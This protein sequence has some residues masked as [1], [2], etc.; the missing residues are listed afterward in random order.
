MGKINFEKTRPLWNNSDPRSQ[1]HNAE[2]I[3]GKTTHGTHTRLLATLKTFYLQPPS[4]NWLSEK[5]FIPKIKK[6]TAPE[7]PKHCS[8]I[9]C[10]KTMDQQIHFPQT[11]QKFVSPETTTERNSPVTWTRFRKKNSSHKFHSGARKCKQWTLQNFTMRI[12]FLSH[13]HKTKSCQ[14]SKQ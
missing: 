9:G 14:K 11:N 1:K 2:R 7:Y 3:E 4:P 12:S 10:S 8:K 13:H 6:T 5:Q